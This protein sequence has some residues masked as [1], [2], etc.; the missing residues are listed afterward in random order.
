M[1]SWQKNI[2]ITVLT[3]L[4]V[5]LFS[6]VQGFVTFK[7]KQE[8]LNS[9]NTIEHFQIK[10]DIQISRKTIL[11]NLERINNNILKLKDSVSVTNQRIERINYKINGM[12]RKIKFIFQN[13]S[14]LQK[15]K[16]FFSQNL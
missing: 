2:L 6:S 7:A 4:I 13:T 15:Y 14:E 11:K 3:A 16:P 9:T 1:K 10:N 12:D 8:V 5:W